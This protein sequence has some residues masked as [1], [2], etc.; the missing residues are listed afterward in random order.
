MRKPRAVAACRRPSLARTDPPLRFRRRSGG[1]LPLLRITVAA[2]GGRLDD[3]RFAGIDHGGVGALQP[4][5]AAVVTAYPVLADLAALAACQSERVHAAMPGQDRAFHLLEETDGAADA[6]A[7]IPFAAPARAFTD[8]KILEQHR[9]AELEHF[10]IGEARVGHVGVH[11][12]GAVE[13]WTRRR[14]R[15]DRLVV[16]ML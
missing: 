1:L 8:V 16:L 2:G 5:H 11:R 10:R 3:H 9:I 7:G 15:A 13:S 4:L 14:A 6:V 12:I